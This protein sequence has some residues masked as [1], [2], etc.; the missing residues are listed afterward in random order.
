MMH[1][2]LRRFCLDLPATSE[3]MPFGDDTLVFRVGGRKIF[4]L[5]GLGQ[6]PPS[7]NLKCE[8]LAAL[9]LRATWGSVRPGYHMS[10]K[11]WNTVSLDGTI[12]RS[13]VEQWIRDS[14]GLVV[15]SLPRSEREAITALGAPGQK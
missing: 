15:A 1:E 2:A 12:P 9:E 5:L 7:I 14:W 6:D 13:L 8:P 3:D 11:H 4:A 10:K